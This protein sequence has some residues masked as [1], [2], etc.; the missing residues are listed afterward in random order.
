MVSV[1]A[2]QI[3]LGSSASEPVIKGQSFLQAYLLHTHPAA[4]RPTGPPIPRTEAMAPSTSAL[5][6]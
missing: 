2:S 4:M 1:S 5:T 3:M 6:G